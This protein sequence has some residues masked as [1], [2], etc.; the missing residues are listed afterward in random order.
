M[1]GQAVP[2]LRH[3][4]EAPFTRRAWSELGH[5]LASFPVAASAFV[6]FV[7][8]LHNGIFWAISAPVVRWHQGVARSLSRTLLG[9]DI[10]AVDDSAARLRGIERDLHDGTQAQLVAL[11]M[12]LG[13][14]MEKLDTAAPADLPRVAQ[15]VGDAHRRA[16][17]AIA[18]RFAVSERAVEKHISNIFSEL[19]LPPSDSGHRRVLA[20]LA[21]LDER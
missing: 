18:D 13:L 2:P 12:K 1:T 9:E 20:A 15:L 21:F 16:L 8:M 6:I 11:A 10:P 5:T 17:E 4:I 19:G 3:V 14:A 7:P